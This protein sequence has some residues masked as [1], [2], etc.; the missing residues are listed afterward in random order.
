MEDLYSFY[1]KVHF[2]TGEIFDVSEDAPDDS[3]DS[4]DFAF[5]NVCSQYPEADIEYIGCEKN[6]WL[7]I[8]NLK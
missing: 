5:N 7:F 6:Y 3:D 8:I 1:F 2:D 4:R